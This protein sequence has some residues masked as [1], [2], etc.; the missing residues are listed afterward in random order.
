MVLVSTAALATVTFDPATGLGFVGKGDVQVALNLNNAQ[1][2]AKAGSLIFSYDDTAAYEATCSWITGE[3]TRG[4]RTH[5][6]SLPRHTRVTDS[7]SYDARTHKQVDGFI[8]T[9][10]GATSTTGTVPVL[11]EPCVDDNG[12]GIAQNGTWSYVSDPIS[13]GGVLSVNGIALTI[14]PTL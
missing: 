12:D 14:T 13:S 2:Q 10:L 4:E 8:L 1:M 11:N 6:V 7:V 9:G 3:G 5:N